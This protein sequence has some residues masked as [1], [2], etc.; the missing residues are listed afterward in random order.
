MQ[1]SEIYFV[2]KEKEQ[3]LQTPLNKTKDAEIQNSSE[4]GAKETD[5]EK[6]VLSKE[7]SIDQA[8]S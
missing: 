5:G 8:P 3:S 2:I 1:I 4:H 6:A 7:D